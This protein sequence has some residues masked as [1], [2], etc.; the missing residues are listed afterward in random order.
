MGLVRMIRQRCIARTAQAT[1]H[2]KLQTGEPLSSVPNPPT[3]KAILFDMDDTLIDWSTRSVDWVDYRRSHL[4]LVYD[5]VHDEL[6]PLHKPNSR[7]EFI[8]A[9]VRA[10]ETA[11]GESIGTMRAPHIGTCIAQALQTIGVPG[12]LLHRERLLRAYE[13]GPVDGV[14]VFPDVAEVLP[15]L[16]ESGLL[17]GIVTN[18][19]QPMWLR[20]IELRAFGLS[21]YINGPRVS[22]AD[23]GWLKPHAHIFNTA[24]SLL[25]GVSVDEV[26]FVGD[27]PIAD[28]VGAKGVGMKAILRYLESGSNRVHEAEPDGEIETF[29]D[30][31]NI[32]DAWYPGWRRVSPAAQQVAR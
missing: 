26:V 3:L 6:Y 28:I 27:N 10:I 18:S 14:R 9:A 22:A 17:L 7:E 25:P 31:L 29:H 13:W 30:L 21:D 16:L 20:D 15:I 32:L 19:S 23:V 8:A 5:F 1:I 2:P 12:E 11:W 4:E 24:L